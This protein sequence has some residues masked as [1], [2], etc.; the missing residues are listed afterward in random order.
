[1]L[2]PQTVEN[3]EEN[4]GLIKTFLMQLQLH[5]VHTACA[6]KINE[7]F[8]H[9]FHK[10]KNA[11]WVV[12]TAQKQVQKPFWLLNWISIARVAALSA[13][14]PKVTV[15]LSHSHWQPEQLSRDSYLLGNACLTCQSCARALPQELQGS[16]SDFAVKTFVCLEM[17]LG[18]IARWLAG[19][20]TWT[21]TWTLPPTGSK[22]L[23]S[24]RRNCV[25][26][27][28]FLKVHWRCR[29]WSEARAVTIF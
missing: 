13:L 10:I 16:A 3:R 18:V 21:K 4:V 28:F 6:G 20:W 27:G 11:I 1:M 2:Y 15:G 17:P 22:L 12:S 24:H 5:R 14:L 26:F 25:E 7:N 8:V 29:Y 23:Q 9:D 19:A